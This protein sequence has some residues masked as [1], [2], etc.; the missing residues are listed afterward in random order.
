V[1]TAPLNPTERF[2][3]RVADYGRYRPRYPAEVGDVLGREVGL[4]AGVVVAGLGSGTGIAS[5]LLLQQD[6]TVLAVEPN[7]AMR[8]EAERRF[9][10][11][12]RFRSVKGTAEAT[13]LPSVSVR[14]ALAA[15]AFHWFE[16]RSARREVGRILEPGGWAALLWNDRRTDGSA[17]ARA[18]E[19]LLREFG[20]DYEQVRHRSG[21]AREPRELFGGPYQTCS[22]PNAQR[23]D[24]AGLRGRVLSSSYTPAADDPRREAM[25]EALREIFDTHQEDGHVR[26]DY[27]TKLYLGH[28]YQ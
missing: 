14:L 9:E 16:P 3:N 7:D 5:E 6:C 13:T 18:Y 19:A 22:F 26:F 2:T 11:E 23:F 24:F 27:D 12:P 25:L 20:T 17:F 28:I 10:H 21:D 15:Q 8:A 4:R 1:T